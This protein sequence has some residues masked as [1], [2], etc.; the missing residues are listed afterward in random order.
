[1]MQWTTLAL[2]NVRRNGRRALLLSG[3]IAVGTLA[4]ILFVSYIAAA[5]DGLRES[6]IRSGLG[7]AQLAGVGQFDGY[8]DQQLQFGLE[9]VRLERLE[10]LLAGQAQ[11]RRV[12]PRLQFS[13]L[14][15]NGP[16]TL[17]FEG[18]GVMPER[19]RQAFGAFQTLSAGAPL[20]VGPEGRFQVLLGK[21]MARRLAVRPGQS[22][23]LMTSTVSGSINAIDVDVAG[24]VATGVPQTDL[25]LLQLP[26]ETAQDLLRT[27]K[28]S[29]V[30]VLYRD[31]AQAD[32]TSALLRGMLAQEGGIELRSWQEL[33]PLYAQVLALYG[34]QFAVFGVVICIVVFLGVAA[35]TLTTIYERS[36][37][38]GTMRAMGIPHAMVRRLFVLEGLLQGVAG[39]CAGALAAYCATL[40]INA[41]HVE[42]AP[43]PGRNVGVLL[44]LL[45]VPEYSAAIVCVLPLVAMAAAWFVSRRIGRMPILASLSLQ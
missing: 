43:P 34:N 15:S 19:E 38:I 26:L 36:K 30:A 1:M 22:V 25:Y 35:M 12:V 24:L 40:L 14:V 37:E 18:T 16:R 2:R 20:R 9:R 41:A 42:L 39:A 13:G 17:N 31:T 29:N 23:T 45:W 4:L 8:A 10:V 27:D 28:V 5:L 32:A 33:A 3:T 7:H 11:V 44:Q 6:T 21:E